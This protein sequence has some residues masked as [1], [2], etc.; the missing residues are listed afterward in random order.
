MQHLDV[1]WL[2]LNGREMWSE[3]GLLMHERVIEGT[4]GTDL[5][6]TI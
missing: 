5:N 2:V 3:R 1:A 6:D 4:V